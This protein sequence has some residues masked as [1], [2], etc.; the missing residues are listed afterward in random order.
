MPI[1]NWDQDKERILNRLR[2][3]A[4]LKL[5]VK[6][7]DEPWLVESWIQHHAKIVGFDNL[8]IADN[9]STDLLT[10]GV[11]E[12]YQAVTT[13]FQFGGPHNQI[14]WHPR[15]SELFDVIRKTCRYFSFVDVDE[16]LVYIDQ[17]SWIADKS[18]ITMIDKSTAEGIIPTT[19]L[20]NT[21]NSFDTFS[22][23]DSELR[24][25]IQNNLK[26]GKPLLTADLAGIQPGIHNDQF[27]D[28]PFST[29]FGVNFFLLHYT[30]FPERRI[31]ANRNKLISRGIIDPSVTSQ[32]IVTMQFHDHLDKSFL[33]FVNEIKDMFQII[34]SPTKEIAVHSLDSLRLNEDG[35]IQYSSDHAREVLSEFLGN[36]PALIALTFGGDPEA[37]Q[38][39]DAHSLL[40]FAIK[41]RAQGKG[42]QAERLFRRGMALYPDFLDQYG[43]PAFRKELMRT[44]LARREWAKANGISPSQGDSG[45][46]YWHHILFA[47]AYSEIGDVKMAMKWWRMVL[48]HEPNNGEA[49]AFLR[50]TSSD[51]A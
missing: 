10:L 22:L 40:V 43:G 38:L 35:S 27:S 36:G 23:L 50:A 16:R 13:I 7:L 47:R 3:K 21:L 30:Q 15:F 24:P 31:S 51:S 14:H 17:R 34:D 28:F 8:I 44:F 6:L 18:I 42:G 25:Q 48:E 46:M 4:T 49:R 9:G 11:Y 33:R 12:K 2:A 41:R 37:D 39:N 1:Y 20:I 45:G 5:C 29:E 19:W 32:D 26:W